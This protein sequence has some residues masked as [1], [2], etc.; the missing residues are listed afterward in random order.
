MSNFIAERSSVEAEAKNTSIQRITMKTK[1]KRPP[2][3]K[4]LEAGTDF[5]KAPLIVAPNTNITN[6]ST[7]NGLATNYYLENEDTMEGSDLEELEINLSP[8]TKVKECPI[9]IGRSVH[10]SWIKVG[11]IAE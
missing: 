2:S 9:E 4:I 8:S 3:S 10:F 1:N 7:A 11:K 6:N 5:S